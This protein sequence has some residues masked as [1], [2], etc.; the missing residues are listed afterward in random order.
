MERKPD[1]G[2]QEYQNRHSP[3]DYEIIMSFFRGVGRFF[4]ALLIHLYRR[5]WFILGTV[6][7]AVASGY[8]WHSRSVL[9]Y[10]MVISTDN[11]PLNAADVYSVIEGLNRNLEDDSVGRNVEWLRHEAV[12]DTVAYGGMV[13]ARNYAIIRLGTRLEGNGAEFTQWVR[14]KVNTDPFILERLE[15]VRSESRRKV[16]DNDKLIHMTEELLRKDRGGDLPLEGRRDRLAQR[17]QD[18]SYDEYLKTLM[19]LRRENLRL[20]QVL[21]SKD[22]FSILSPFG[23]PVRSRGL[24]FHVGL[25]WFFWLLVLSFFDVLRWTKRKAQT[26]SSPQPS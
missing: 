26:W 9:E 1:V 2:M 18:P 3:T 14:M 11:S 7:L 22:C 25:A 15:K 6:V 20:E 17:M 10:R 12:M 13:N 19:Q 24:L 4:T 23:M 16:E 8:A 5:R 21:S